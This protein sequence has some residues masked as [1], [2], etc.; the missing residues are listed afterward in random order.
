MVRNRVIVKRLNSIE[1]LGAMN[2]LCIDKTGTLTMDRIILER[3]L[4]VLG[5]ADEEV[6]RYAYL[7]S[8][9]QTGLKN[10]LDAAIL[11]HGELH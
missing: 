1:D 10:L 6:L 5:N 8:Y 7:N 11:E 9:F 2:L 4:D 3:H